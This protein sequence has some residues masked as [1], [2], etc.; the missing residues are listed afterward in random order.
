MKSGTTKKNYDEEKGMLK[1][2]FL[3]TS[4]LNI[5]LNTK[6]LQIYLRWTFSHCIHVSQKFPCVDILLNLKKLKNKKN[7]LFKKIKNKKN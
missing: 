4:Q 6:S 1:T 7:E 5:T 2:F 3:S